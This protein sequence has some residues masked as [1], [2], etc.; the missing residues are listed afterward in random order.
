MPSVSKQ[1]AARSNQWPRGSAAGCAAQFP[2]PTAVL[3]SATRKL[4]SI[5]HCLSPPLLTL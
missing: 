3:M 4:V 5:L 1:V 2:L